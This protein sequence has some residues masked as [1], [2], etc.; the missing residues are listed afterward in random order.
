M[1]IKIKTS[2]R[3]HNSTNGNKLIIGRI[4]IVDKLQHLFDLWIR[5]QKLGG[6][7]EGTVRRKERG[8]DEIGRVLVPNRKC[9]Q[10]TWIFV[11][12]PSASWRLVVEE[13]L[14]QQARQIQNHWSL[15]LQSQDFI[16]VV[17]EPGQK[18]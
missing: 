10:R 7:H 4:T 11:E 3:Q 17:H 13:H 9:D 16:L 6:F 18:P 14:H 12:T 8:K 5:E 2:K 1:G 15:S